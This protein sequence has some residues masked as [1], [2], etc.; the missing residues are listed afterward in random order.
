VG[1][2]DDTWDTP[3]NPYVG[4]WDV[5]AVKLNNNGVRQWHTFLG[6]ADWDEG[7]AI[8]VD[9]SGNVYVAGNSESTWGTPVN[10]HAGN[11][12]AFA[13]KLDS[14][15]VL[16]WHTFLGSAD[17]DHSYAIEED[18]SGDVY[19]AGDSYAT[20]NTPDN[21]YAGS[22]DAFVAKLNS[23]NGARQWH[24]F[25]GSTGHDAAHGITVDRSG[26]VYVVGYSESTWGTPV[27]PHA[28]ETDVF[29]AK[30]GAFVSYLPIILKSY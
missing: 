3:V 13:A 27:N 4:S 5:F 30:I 23:N 24:T 18:G 25:L 16:E 10:P 22:A 17:W 11:W 28:G 8:A 20:W 26:S 1:Q 2:G 29:V 19:V 21:P 12:D 6:S 9:E 15:G 7:Y 14:S